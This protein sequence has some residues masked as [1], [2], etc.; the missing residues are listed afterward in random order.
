[1]TGWGSLVDVLDAIDW[2]L[3]KGPWLSGDRFSAADLYISAQLGFA[4]MFGVVEARPSFQD[5]VAR[6]SA[7]PAAKRAHEIDEALMSEH[8]MPG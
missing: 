5:Y 7:R 4:M 6:A 2:Q 3:A 8:P 1:M